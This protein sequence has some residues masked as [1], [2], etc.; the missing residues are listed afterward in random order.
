MRFHPGSGRPCR[1]CNCDQPQ[2]QHRLQGGRGD[3]APDVADGDGVAKFQAEHLRGV[4]RGSAQPMI[5]VLRFGIIASPALNWCC[6]VRV[7]FARLL[8]VSMSF[9]SDERRRD[10]GVVHRDVVG[11]RG[12]TS[13]QCQRSKCAQPAHAGRDEAA[14]VQPAHEG[15]V[16][17][18]D[19]LIAER[20]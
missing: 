16:D 7:A 9:L 20:G 15:R 11:C 17:V 13:G 18:V 6:E 1:V 8:T 10:V 19:E 2:H 12:G 14:H 3:P 5:I 4:T